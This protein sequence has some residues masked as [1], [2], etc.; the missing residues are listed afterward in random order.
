MRYCR[1]ENISGNIYGRLKVLT[2]SHTA[3]NGA[4]Y[5]TCI[6]DCGTI[7]TTKAARLKSGKTVSCGCYA[8]EV[9]TRRNLTHGYSGA[10]AT[11][12]QKRT[13]QSWFSMVNRCVNP[14][15]PNYRHYGGRGITVTPRWLEFATFVEDMGLCEDG[16]SIERVDVNGN[17]E[18][19]NCVWLLRILQAKNRR[20][21]T[22]VEYD[23]TRLCLTDA[24][25]LVNLPYHTVRYHVAKG[26]DFSSVVKQLKGTLNV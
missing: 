7:V 12:A 19:S 17:Y 5:W 21:T 1:V 25:K 9:T 18:P 11:I 16:Y 13:Y 24:C 3:S 14:N 10:S 20:T 2:F 15:D 26:R 4:A 23:G 6:C 22:F 8:R